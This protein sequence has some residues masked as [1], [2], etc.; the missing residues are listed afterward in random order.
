MLVVGLGPAH[1]MAQSLVINSGEGAATIT[2]SESI[3]VKEE[4]TT[5]DVNLWDNEW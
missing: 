1:M 5:D 2:S 4:N 3:F